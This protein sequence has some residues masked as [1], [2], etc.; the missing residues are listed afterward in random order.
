VEARQSK[1]SA[2]ERFPLPPSQEIHL[3]HKPYPLQMPPAPYFGSNG[4][5]GRPETPSD[6]RRFGSWTAKNI[7]KLIQQPNYK[8]QQCDFTIFGQ[9][10]FTI[11]VIISCS[12]LSPSQAA[13][14]GTIFL[15]KPSEHST[16]VVSLAAATSGLQINSMQSDDRQLCQ[17]NT[18]V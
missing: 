16:N 9:I 4:P 18:T 2:L 7:V 10:T 17:K 8:S 5:P 14:K 1:R 15:A 12:S 11:D 13:T 3:R 6:S